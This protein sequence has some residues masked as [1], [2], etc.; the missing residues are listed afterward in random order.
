MQSRQR[1]LAFCQSNTLQFCSLR[2]AQ[3]S[4]MRI[5]HELLHG[6]PQPERADYCT[7]ECLHGRRDVGALMVA[8]DLCQNWVHPECVG[9]S[10]GEKAAK[11]F[12]CPACAQ[13][14]DSSNPMALDVLS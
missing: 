5:L 9:L 4:S 12:T 10:S 14:E 6:S 7:P 8:C 11:A 13:A 2:Y 1:L 3:Y